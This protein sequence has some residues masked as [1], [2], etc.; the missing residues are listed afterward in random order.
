MKQD[1]EPS[2]TRAF[3]VTGPLGVETEIEMTSEGTMELNSG[4]E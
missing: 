1:V 2:S 3:D 4:L